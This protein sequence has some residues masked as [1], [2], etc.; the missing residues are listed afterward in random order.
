MN[1]IL[2]T[3]E[4]N[5]E[6]DV[7]KSTQPVIVDF[8]AEWCGPCKMLA[9]VLGE[10]AAEQ[11]ERVKIVKV[12]VDENPALAQQY[13][14]QSIPTLLYF[15]NGLVYERVVGVVSKKTIVS[16]LEAVATR[17]ANLNLTNQSV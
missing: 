10:I 3:N 8:W 11:A 7:I 1:S 14:I 13:K 6:T 5:F 9:P 16:K 17:A 15:V 12:N 2:E 4:T